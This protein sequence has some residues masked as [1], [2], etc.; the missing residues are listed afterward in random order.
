MFFDEELSNGANALP[1]PVQ[2][3]Q[4]SGLLVP[5]GCFPSRSTDTPTVVHAWRL[6]IAFYDMK[7]RAGRGTMS[8]LSVLPVCGVS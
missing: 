3:N 2:I 7:V 8:G 6:L 1:V 4:Q 5:F